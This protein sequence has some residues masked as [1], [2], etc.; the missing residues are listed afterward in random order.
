MDQTKR[1]PG[2]SEDTNSDDSMEQSLILKGHQN[3]SCDLD[4]EDECGVG[5][6]YKCEFCDKTFR[7]EGRLRRHYRVHTE[8]KPFE[9]TYCGKCFKQSS[10]LQ[11]HVLI[12][13]SD[14]PFNCTICEKSFKRP[15]HLERHKLTHIEERPFRCIVCHRGFRELK[16]LFRHQ[17]VH[18]EEQPQCEVCES[19]LLKCLCKYLEVHKELKEKC[20][21]AQELKTDKTYKGQ[22]DQSAY[23]MKIHQRVLYEN[24]SSVTTEVVVKSEGVDDV[25]LS[26]V[27][28]K[29]EPYD[30]T[31][32]LHSKLDI[33]QQDHGQSHSPYKCDVCNRRFQNLGSLFKHQFHHLKKVRNYVCSVCRK[34]CYSPSELAMHQNTHGEPVHRCNACGRMFKTV[35]YL[36]RHQ[37]VHSGLQPFQCS[38]C[39][40]KFSRLSNLK[41][42]YMIHTGEKPFT[43]SHCGKSFKESTE[44]IRHQWKNHDEKTSL[45]NK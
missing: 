39:D 10:H 20:N 15:S 31:D 34:I 14:R 6:G 42:H 27:H 4:G 22:V 8:E 17:M 38:F 26:S 40:R 45:L 3:D 32:E 21:S 19:S 36:M 43:C 2:D 11:Q 28:I 41:R 33:E 35:Q 7:L 30:S 5:K 44:L 9:C 12:H 24:D 16:E 25:Q 18:L 29:E 37:A 23:I 1:E 13:T